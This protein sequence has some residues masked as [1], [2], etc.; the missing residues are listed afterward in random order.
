MDGPSDGPAAA[1]SG[2]AEL[3]GDRRRD[4][5]DPTLVKTFTKRLPV[6]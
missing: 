2:S 5:V 6:V 3:N 1:G 4:V